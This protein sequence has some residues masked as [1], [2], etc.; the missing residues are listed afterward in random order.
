M[1]E[2]TVVQ[3]GVLF[4][5][6]ADEKNLDRVERLSESLIVRYCKVCGR[7]HFEETLDPIQ[8]GVKGSGL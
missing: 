7:R 1:G 2:E 6:C 5:C 4:P 3:G 8:I